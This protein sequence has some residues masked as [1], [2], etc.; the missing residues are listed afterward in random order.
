MAIPAG[1]HRW[2]L[3]VREELAA[4]ADLYD[5]EV[6]DEVRRWLETLADAAVLGEFAQI[7]SGRGGC[8]AP[9]QCNSRALGGGFTGA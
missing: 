1:R 7:G 6:E 2:L 4:G 8:H 3:G 9:C 5:I